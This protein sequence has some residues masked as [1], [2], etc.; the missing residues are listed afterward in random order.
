MENHSFQADAQQILRLVTHSIY[1]DR[2]VFLRELLS[3][4]S[5]ALNK[6]RVISLKSDGNYRDIEEPSIRVLFDEEE[7]TLTLESLFI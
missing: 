4:A 7:K 6:A 2:E 3:N 5:D 1:S